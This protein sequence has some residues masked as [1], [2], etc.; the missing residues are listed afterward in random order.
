MD[1]SE[2]E[3]A[4]FALLEKKMRTMCIKEEELF[5]VPICEKLSKLIEIMIEEEKNDD[6]EIIY[7]KERES[8]IKELETG[9]QEPS[10]KVKINEENLM[11]INTQETNP[12][13]F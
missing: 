11:N 13:Y 8:F 9:L 5:Y 6:G 7:S 10:I 2:Y 12:E 1:E 3:E 4:V